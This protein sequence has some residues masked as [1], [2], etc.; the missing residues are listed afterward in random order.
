MVVARFLRGETEQE[1]AVRIG[2]LRPFKEGIV[3]ALHLYRYT[4][5]GEAVPGIT[6]QAAAHGNAVPGRIEFFQLVKHQFVGGQNKFID[7][8]RLIRQLIHFQGKTAVA[9]APGQHKL[10]RCGAPGVG[11]KFLTGEPI[12]L[13][14]QQADLYGAAL[15]HRQALRRVSLE[16]HRLEPDGIAGMIRS[17]VL[18]EITI[19]G[20]GIRA[21]LTGFPQAHGPGLPVPAHRHHLIIALAAE[22]LDKGRWQQRETAE[23]Q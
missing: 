11:G 7:P 9:K 3:V 4:R 12:P 1:T 19:R 2:L 6:L 18:I 20:N 15:A 14:I 16:H 21:L 13:G 5:A 10:A 22:L 23:F 8:E 17:L